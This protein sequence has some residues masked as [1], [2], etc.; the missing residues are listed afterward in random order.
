MLDIVEREQVMM[1]LEKETE[2]AQFN[3]T[4]SHP[5]A[6]QLNISECVCAT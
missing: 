5:W 2:K 4:H 6:L 1:E 3:I